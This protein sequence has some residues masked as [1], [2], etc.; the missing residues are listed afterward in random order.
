MTPGVR[1]EILVGNEETTAAAKWPP[2]LVD[3]G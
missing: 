3:E 2:T 1:R